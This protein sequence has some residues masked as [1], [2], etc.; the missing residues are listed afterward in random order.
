MFMK[1]IRGSSVKVEP[2]FYPP[3]MP[4][5]A[6][7]KMEP[8]FV[9]GHPYIHQP[10]P[11]RFPFFMPHPFLHGLSPLSPHVPFPHRPPMTRLQDTQ[12]SSAERHLQ[13]QAVTEKSAYKTEDDSSVLDLSVKKTSRSNSTVSN[14][15]T[16]LNAGPEDFTCDP[17]A[18]QEQG[19]DL[20][21]P[22]KQNGGKTFKKA[23]LNRYNSKFVILSGFSLDFCRWLSNK[24][25]FLIPNIDNRKSN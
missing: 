21:C 8:A 5:P 7:M 22:D 9:P 17:M 16:E 15:N 20:S 1:G 4:I 3:A 6:P 25:F 13:K 14:S 24:L 23:L 19:L 18:E 11:M 2:G 12:D 10:Q